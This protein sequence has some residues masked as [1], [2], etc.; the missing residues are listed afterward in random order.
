MKHEV[1][2]FFVRYAS[3]NSSSDVLSIGDF[4]ADTFLFG[5]TSGVQPVKKE[6]FL[7]F[8]PKMKAHFS[9]MGL[10][11]T[12]LQAMRGNPISSKYYLAHIG[13]RMTIRKSVGTSQID[14]LASYILAEESGG[15]LSIVFQIDH[16]D[17]ATVIRDQQNAPE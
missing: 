4:Y 16:Q 1:E 12:E 8:I 14:A 6:E 10:L 2:Q 11:Q 15:G 9:S 3:A 13:W 17:L 5:G 7:G